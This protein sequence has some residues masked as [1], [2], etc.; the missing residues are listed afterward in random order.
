M[1]EDGVMRYDLVYGETSRDFTYIDNVIQMNLLAGTTDNPE[2]FGAAFNVAVGG[3]NTLNE[4]YTLINKE[5]DTHIES[6]TETEAIYRDFRAGDI[7][8]SN[9]NIAK[10]QK[11]VGYAP[12]HDIYQGMEEAIE[13]YIESIG[14]N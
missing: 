14:Q 2:A 3:R 6:F 9:A 5:L 10:A 12:T 11:T 4:L 7:R 13:W 8:H 1:L